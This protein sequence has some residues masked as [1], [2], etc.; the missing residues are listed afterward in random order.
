MS[1]ESPSKLKKRAASDR[2]YDT[3][4]SNIQSLPDDIQITL[5]EKVL[6]RQREEYKKLNPLYSQKYAPL[7]FYMSGELPLQAF[8]FE[9]DKKLY[10]IVVVYESVDAS[11]IDPSVRPFGR[12]VEMKHIES[13]DLWGS[14]TRYISFD[15]SHRIVSVSNLG[16]APQNH[17]VP[18]LNA[19][20][21]I[22]RKFMPNLTPG[23]LKVHDGTLMYT[24]DGSVDLHLL[25][26]EEY[27][28]HAKEGHEGGKSRKEHLMFNHRRYKVHTDKEK[29]RYIH[30]QR[31][32]VYLSTIQGKYRYCA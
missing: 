1:Q 11:E 24:S 2:E 10:R 7:N 12:D 32:K 19:F 29:K 27:M 26:L 6:Q 8:D 22:I 21:M 16:E 9:Y 14:T 3:L 15:V 18:L 5:W 31:E 20:I 25:S 4:I 13:I 23:D 17:H 28:K 30:V